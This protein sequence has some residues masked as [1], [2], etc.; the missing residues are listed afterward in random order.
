MKEIRELFSP[1]ETPQLGSRVVSSKSKRLVSRGGGGCGPC[2]SVLPGALDALER[3]AGRAD[4]EPRA[5]RR[6]GGGAPGRLREL[7]T[8]AHGEL[9]RPSPAAGGAATPADSSTHRPGA[10]TRR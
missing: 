8:V 2:G 10:G 9:H 7:S 4:P 6:A 5:D 3:H 1:H